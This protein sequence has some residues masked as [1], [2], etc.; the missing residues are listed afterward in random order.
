[1]A[2]HGCPNKVGR[3]ARGQRRLIRKRL[4]NCKEPTQWTS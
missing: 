2:S 4:E 3:I 1:M